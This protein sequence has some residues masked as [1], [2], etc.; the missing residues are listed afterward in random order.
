MRTQI[1]RQRAEAKD[2]LNELRQDECEEDGGDRFFF[3]FRHAFLPDAARMAAPTSRE[4]IAQLRSE[5]RCDSRDAGMPRKVSSLRSVE[6][7]SK[8]SA[9]NVF[10]TALFAAPRAN[11]PLF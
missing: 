2:P 7:Q 9:K 1:H 4:P 6:N 11:P 3:F 5:W 10:W 8:G